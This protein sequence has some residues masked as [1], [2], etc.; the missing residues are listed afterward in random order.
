MRGKCNQAALTHH[1]ASRAAT[2]PLEEPTLNNETTELLV[3][4][5][6]LCS[7]CKE[8]SKGTIAVL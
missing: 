1:R 5:L 2:V 8:L 7:N 6:S 4:C 3:V